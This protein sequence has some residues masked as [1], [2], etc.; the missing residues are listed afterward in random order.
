MR[1]SRRVIGVAVAAAGA[2]LMLAAPAAAHVEADPSRVKP[3]KQVTVVFAAEH[4]CDESPTTGMTFRVPKGVTDAAPVE[5]VG[6]TS[7]VDGRKIVFSGGSIPGD[8]EAPFEITFTAPDEKGQLVWKVVQ[9]CEEGVE[10]WIETDP[11]GDKP[12]PRVGVGEKPESGHDDDED[13]HRAP[14]SGTS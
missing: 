9:G 4:G 14:R 8:D 12:A 13:E 11:D 5:K 3:G 1:T 2:V 7:N 10:R 6:F